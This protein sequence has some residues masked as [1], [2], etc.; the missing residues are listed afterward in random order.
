MMTMMI[1]KR[2]VVFF[3]LL[4]TLTVSAQD[5]DFGIWYGISAEHKL[6]KKIEINLSTNVRTI[7]NASKVEEAFLEGGL[8]YSLNS[9][10][11]LA[12]AYRVT[13]KVEDNNKYYFQH[14]FLFDFKAGDQVKNINLSLRLRFQARTKTYIQDENDDKPDYTGRIKLKA[15]YKTPAFPLNP[16][17]YVESFCPVFSDKSKTIEKNRFS[18]GVEFSI[19]K[20]HSAELE[21]IFQRDYLPHLS[22]MN[23]ISIN[24]NI[25]F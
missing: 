14:K 9:H 22:D 16:Y 3:L 7:N 8:A 13:D 11:A 2:L 6:T 4:L 5:K 25:K 17:I 18:A 15:V 19:A 12:G 24:Y 20:R 21:Y 10:L 23:I 1:K